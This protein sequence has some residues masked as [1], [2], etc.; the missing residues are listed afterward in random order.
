MERSYENESKVIIESH[1]SIQSSV[2]SSC[3]IRTPRN[4]AG[5][6]PQEIALIDSTKQGMSDEKDEKV[7]NVITKV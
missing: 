2:S 1:P 4:R 7:G 3:C 6:G 5:I